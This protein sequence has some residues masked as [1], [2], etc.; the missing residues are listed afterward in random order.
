M[1]RC[2]ATY[3]CAWAPIRSRSLAVVDQPQ[4]RRLDLVRRAGVHAG[5]AVLD[6]GVDVGVRDER[7]AE[8][9]RLEPAQV[10]LAA[11]QVVLGRRARS[12]CRTASSTPGRPR[13]AR[14]E[15]DRALGPNSS[16]YSAAAAWPTDTKRASG[17]ARR[18]SRIAGSQRA[19]DALWPTPPAQPIVTPLR[20]GFGQRVALEVDAVVTRPGALVERAVAAREVVGRADDAVGDAHRHLHLARRS[21]RRRCRSARAT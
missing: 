16:T 18:T 20:A 1:R 5:D 10:A 17:R 2:S 3:S 21:R 6:V 8:R 13:S 14:R 15:A 4:Q 7:D 19:S 12:R 11:E 9:A